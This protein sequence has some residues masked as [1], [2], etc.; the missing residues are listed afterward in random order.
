MSRYTFT[1]QV[2]SSL[3]HVV[4]QPPKERATTR[5]R[6][7]GVALT[8]VACAALAA[9]F[10]AHSFAGR[11]PYQHQQTD[12][13]IVR[14]VVVG[15]HPVAE[16][17]DAHWH[18]LFVVNQGDLVHRG[19]VMMLDTRTGRV[20]RM[21]VVGNSPEAIAVDPRSAQAFVATDNGIMSVLDTRTG[22]VVRSV[23]LA[24]PLSAVVVD[25]VASHVLVAGNL[26]NGGF[27]ANSGFV[28]VLAARDGR[29]L[30]TAFIRFRPG[31]L[32]VDAPLAR[33]VVTGWRIIHQGTI[34]IA[35]G[36]VSVLDTRSGRIVR[37]VPIGRNL[38]PVGIDTHTRRAFVADLDSSGGV[39][40]IDMLDAASGRLLRIVKLAFAPIALTV[41]EATGRVFVC[42]QGAPGAVVVLDAYTGQLI[43]TTT[44]YA[45]M[46]LKPW[47]TTIV[48]DETR[49]HII[50]VGSQGTD[51]L[52]SRNGVILRTLSVPGDSV[53]IDNQSGH[54]FTSYSKDDSLA[55]TTTQKTGHTTILDIKI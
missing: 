40:H 9:A 21:I 45:G 39:G 19:S 10:G 1:K 18:H 49:K 8:V 13:A 52:D 34:P 5:T 4:L 43:S 17:I 32:A 20:E 36:E 35:A 42:G 3:P 30:H 26:G 47:S 29:I 53:A 16:A 54:I 33:A 2:A 15:G 6:R 23:A 37:T 24:G 31:A 48:A 14:T 25:H 51:I 41:S 44:S 50:M 28:T 12:R 46:I 55:S 27:L 38:G 11:H 22:R 7:G